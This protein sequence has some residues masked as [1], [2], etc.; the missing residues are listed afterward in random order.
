MLELHVYVYSNVCD[1]L[2]FFVLLVVLAVYTN[3]LQ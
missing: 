1:I 3:S 2:T